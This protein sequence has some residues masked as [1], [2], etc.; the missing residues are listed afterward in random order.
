MPS[1]A[2]LSLLAFFCEVAVGVG[3]SVERD[4]SAPAQT[5]PRQAGVGSE[6]LLFSLEN[7]KQKARASR[8]RASLSDTITILQDR[9]VCQYS[10]TIARREQDAPPPSNLQQVVV[11]LV[12]T[13]VMYTGKHVCRYLYIAECLPTPLRKAHGSRL[14][15]R[16]AMEAGSLPVPTYGKTHSFYDACYHNVM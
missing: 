6:R 16:A 14:G 2:V 10:R 3:A 8:S 12:H 9:V 5:T 13:A 4:Q 7:P 1:S 15:F 11:C